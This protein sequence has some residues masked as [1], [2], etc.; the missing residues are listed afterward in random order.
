MHFL[1]I[2]LPFL[3]FLQIKELWEEVLGCSNE[4]ELFD[5]SLASKFAETTLTKNNNTHNFQNSALD[6]FYSVEENRVSWQE[7]WSNAKEH[8]D[9]TLEANPK[10]KSLVVTK[11]SNVA[12]HCMS[13]CHPAGKQLN[14][15]EETEIF[16]FQKLFDSLISKCNFEFDPSEALLW[17]DNN[18]GQTATVKIISTIAERL[19]ISLVTYPFDNKNKS[20]EYQPPSIKGK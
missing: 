13:H 3:D 19:F 9:A 18:Q 11:Y 15:E 1:K 7:W 2:Y 20:L 12:V 14:L 8:P 6:F 5:Y 10:T 4:S 16:N 17:F